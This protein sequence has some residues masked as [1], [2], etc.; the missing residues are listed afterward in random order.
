M[1]WIKL[2]RTIKD[3]WIW[4]DSE[5]LKW[6][7]DLLILVNHKDNEKVLIGNKLFNCKRGETLKSL[8]TLSI[9]WMVSR[10]TVRCFLGLLKTD[11][12]ITTTNERVTTRITVCNYEDYQTLPH[13]N[14]TDNTQ[15]PN[16]SQ[17]LADTIKEGL[18]NDKKKEAF[19]KPSLTEIEICFKEGFKKKNA[20]NDA[21]LE[22]EAFFN[23]YES[24]DWFVGKG[25]MKKWRYSVGG[26]IVRMQKDGKLKLMVV[27]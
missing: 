8:K 2:H 15:K 19:K 12:M 16:G 17:T 4:K 6:W 10:D 1:S 11:H 18:K 26:W 24:K 22:S 14:Q 13:V 3:H 27:A 20:M 25:K 23:H 21:A 5:K 7:I 9:R